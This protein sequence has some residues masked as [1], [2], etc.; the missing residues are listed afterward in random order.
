MEFG[1]KQFI[2]LSFLNAVILIEAINL[3]IATDRAVQI[4]SDKYLS[5]AIDT[6]IIRHNWENLNFG[7]PKVE[8]LARALSPCYLRVGGSEADFMKFSPDTHNVRFYN[9]SGLYMSDYY[10]NKFVNFTMFSNQWDELNHF[11]TKVGWSLIFD[12]NSLLRENGQWLPDNA[13]LL[14]DYTSQKGYKITGWELGNEPNSYK[15]HVGYSISGSQRAKDYSKLHSLLNQYPQ[16]RKSVIIGPSTTQLSKT[17][18]EKYFTEFLQTGGPDIVTNPTFHHYYINGREA[19]IDQFM[20]IDILNSLMPEINKGNEIAKHPPFG[21]TWLGETGSAYGGGA[22]GLSDTYVA[23]FMWLDKLGISAVGGLDVLIRQT[24]YGGHYSIIDDKTSDPLPDYWLSYIYKTLVGR[25]VLNVSVDDPEG[26]VRM[27]SHCTNVKRSN[28]TAGSITV[29]GMN[30]GNSFKTIN[31]SQ[32]GDD[33]TLHVYV[34]QPQESLKSQAVTLNGRHLKLNED[35]TL[36]NV[37]IPVIRTGNVTFP[38]QSFGFIVL[39]NSKAEAC[40]TVK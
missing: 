25:S 1:W 11:V 4:V 32:Y 17:S 34:L 26:L 20:D 2:L 24:F 3:K 31:F 28:Y 27:Y 12:L 38:P 15:H 40:Q 36:P 5:I 21:K 33:V 14:M 8:S 13:K 23:G 22:P 37:L 7:S 19:T 16:W 9:Q 35:F 39:P 29:Y 6:G 30:L 10:D 18:A